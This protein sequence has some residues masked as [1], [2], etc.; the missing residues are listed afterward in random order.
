[1]D[2]FKEARRKY[3]EL[4]NRYQSGQLEK[5]AFQKS[6][7][8][9]GF[10]DQ[11]GQMWQIGA[12]SGDW[13][14]LEGSQWV[15]DSPPSPPVEAADD[16]YQ[17]SEM[18]FTGDART[19][20]T[21]PPPPSS[22]PP[23]PPSSSPSPPPPSSS[24]PPPSSPNFSAAPDYG[25]ADTVKPKKKRRGCLIAAV[26]VF[27]ILACLGS[28]FIGFQLISEGEFTREFDFS[29]SSSTSETSIDVDNQ[30][31]FDIC[32]LYIS[33]STSDD[34]GLNLLAPGETIVPGMVTSFPAEV[35]TTVDIYAEDC[36]GNTIDILYEI[37]IPAEGITVT[38]S[39]N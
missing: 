28:V 22:S 39:P 26:V 9:L 18:D 14:R 11:D 4:Q 31:G 17:S 5:Q 24:P 8:E 23:P 27:F 6:V 10:T 1:M 12:A 2:Q 21:Q 16:F 20:V 32:G 37:E 15:K 38:Y 25:D 19:P 29:T 34:W 3:Q 33:P 35:G 13:Y 36:Q 7:E 30:V